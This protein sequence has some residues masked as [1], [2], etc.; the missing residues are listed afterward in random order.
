MSGMVRW[1]GVVLFAAGG[2][3]LV[4]F[5]GCGGGN[6]NGGTPVN[7]DDAAGGDDS[8]TGD[9]TGKVCG[10][11]VVETGEDCDDGAKNGATGDPCNRDCTWVCIQGTL[12][13]DAKC[14]TG[15]PCKGNATCSASHLCVPGTPLG[16][17]TTCTIGAGGDG[18]AGTAGIC[19][20]QVCSPAVCGDGYVTPPEECD[21]GSKNG[22]A[23]DG[24]DSLCKFVCVSTDPTRDCAST[25]PCTGAGTC[26]STSHVCT[27]GTTSP[28]GTPCSPGG[29]AGAGDICK[30]G[31]CTSALCGDGKIEPPE[32]CDPPNG[33][34]CDAQCQ[35]IVCGDGKVGGKEQCDDGNVVNLDGCDSSCNFEQ[36]QRATALKILGST[37]SYCTVNA[38]G[39]LALT[40][41]GLG[42][43]QPALD[44]DIGNGTTNVTFKFTGTGAT[45]ADLSGT[46]GSV[47]LG[48]MNGHPQDADGGAYSG[49]SDL[50]WWYTVDPASID[51]N[52]NPLSLLPGSYTNKQLN[53]G[54]G[55]VSLS[56]TLSGSPATLNMWSV[57]LRAA[58]G[59][60][61]ALKTSTGLPPGHLASEHDLAGLTTFGNAGVGAS[62]PAGELCGNITGQSLAG[63]AVPV[64]IAKGG[65]TSCSE[66]YVVGTNSLLD[67]LV[68]GCHVFFISA[69]NATQPDQ[70]DPT[71]TFPTGTT[72]SY[73]L[74]ASSSTTHVVDTC[75]DGSTPAKTVP[76][77]TCL[78]GLAYSSAFQF[79]TDRVII[80]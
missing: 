26:N 35:L 34:T 75:T 32:T 72:K 1:L 69:V 43:L 29:D 4:P 44:T 77:A 41:T 55:R 14:N 65:T 60:N 18:G 10:N 31:V 52:R 22:T 42:Q 63:V 59:A 46:T 38:L 76:L 9:A 39:H 57:I 53:A 61:A 20:S 36:E 56:L 50:D 47:N 23:A 2:V 49:T 30:A 78:T 40:S 68:G 62:G 11:G 66:G 15:D 33:T 21:D 54:P 67:V 70:Q 48:P 27:P 37:D 7:G 17:G 45:P 3:A 13:G 12:N 25:N 28:D 51:A 73:K 8:T 79:Q 16:D 6:G 71:V 64:K 74:S 24:C 58:I 19:R 80:K 5:A